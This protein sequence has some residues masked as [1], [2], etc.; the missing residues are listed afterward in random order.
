MNQT[1]NSNNDNTNKAIK[2]S[3]SNTLKK[4]PKNKQI[5]MKSIAVLSLFVAVI[6]LIL[7]VNCLDMALAGGMY[8]GSGFG[9]AGGQMGGGM[10]IT[11]DDSPSPLRVKRWHS[12]GELVLLSFLFVGNHSNLKC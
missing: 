12:G 1:S 10:G 11:S 3:N 5:N 2:F 9:G 7:V 8:G 4:A 6:G